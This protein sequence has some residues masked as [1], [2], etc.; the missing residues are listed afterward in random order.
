MMFFRRKIQRLGPYQSLILVLIPVMLAEPLKIVALWVAGEG[1]WLT[2]TAMIV[3]AYAAS[4]LVV[5]RLFKIAKPKLMTLNWFARLW[6]W[7]TDL[8]HTAEAWVRALPAKKHRSAS[9]SEPLA[10]PTAPVRIE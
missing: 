7:F 3:A 4:L 10:P 2:G 9:L 8:R 6:T 1:H 5:E